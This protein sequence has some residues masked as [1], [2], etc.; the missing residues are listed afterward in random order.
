M[1][2]SE[3]INETEK[4]SYRGVTIRQ[5]WG[6]YNGR[7]MP[8]NIK[9]L[10]ATHVKKA[11]NGSL[12]INEYQPSWYAQAYN[13]PSAS[14]ETI[15]M[16]PLKPY[17]TVQRIKE[18]RAFEQAILECMFCEWTLHEDAGSVQF[19]KSKMFD[20]SVRNMSKR[21]SGIDEKLNTFIQIKTQNP[22]QAVN[23]KDKPF[24]GIGP[25]GRALPKLRYVHLGN[26]AILFYELEGRNPTVV[27]L[28]GIFN[29]DDIGIGQPMNIQK[30]KSM[31]KRIAQS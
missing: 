23:S 28:Y 15:V 25:I 5:H 20:D 13:D 30:Q 24:G 2:A 27:K 3:F 12:Y 11:V 18:L 7:P 6:G 14:F 16:G 31:I 26:D 4:K 17:F 8:D 10:A 22:L 19:V 21:L 29:H 1:R 9:K